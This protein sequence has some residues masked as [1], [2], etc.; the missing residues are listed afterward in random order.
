VTEADHRPRSSR[1]KFVLRIEWGSSRRSSPTIA[2]TSKAQSRTSPF[3]L[4]ECSALKS[5][6]PSKPGSRPLN[7]EMALPVLQ[8]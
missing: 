1:S 7:Y 3:R 6:R 5:V 4:F 8:R 2:S